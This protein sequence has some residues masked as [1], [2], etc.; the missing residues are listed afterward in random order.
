[1]AT[2]YD[3]RVAQDRDGGEPVVIATDGSESAEQAVVAGAR[4]ARTLGTTAV[5]VYVRPTIGALG[6]PYY[7]EK[8]SEQMAYGRAALDRAQTLVRT[9]GCEADEEILEGHPPDQVVELALARNA[10][11]IVV[12]SRGLGAVT[13]ASL[14]SVSGAIIHRADRPVLVVPSAVGDV[15][16][17]TPAAATVRRGTADDPRRPR[18]SATCD[19]AGGGKKQAKAAIPSHSPENVRAL[20]PA[21]ETRGSPGGAAT[22]DEMSEWSFPASDPPATWTWEVPEHAERRSAGRDDES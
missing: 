5:L 8:L 15:K 7:Q 9:E 11:L 13:G 2:H 3:P 16:R 18:A 22:V 10:P 14:G 4:M 21:A 19:P 17:R 20:G 12:G 1:M 6:E